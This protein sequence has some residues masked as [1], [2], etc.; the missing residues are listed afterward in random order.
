VWLDL[1]LFAVF[2]AFALLGAWRGALE[3]GLRLAAWVCGYAAAILAAALGGEALASALGTALW[4]GMPLA[5][6]LA[7]VATQALFAVAI[8][9]ARRRGAETE[10]GAGDRILG[11][12]FGATRGALLALLIGWLGLLGDA[13]R[14]EGMLTALPPLEGSV[15]AHWSGL[16]A[17]SGATAALG[18]DPGA[19]AVAA[20]AARP[21]ETLTSL[22]SVI[23]HPRVIALQRDGD[24]W[25]A[26]EA[27]DVE[28]ALSRPSA[29]ALTSDAALRRELAS[30]G[31]VERA[32]AEHPI[33]FERALGDALG[34]VSVRLAELRN[35]PEVRA[36]LEDP[37]VLGLVERGDALGLLAHPRFQSVIRRASAS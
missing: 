22:R 12:A 27:G 20:L 34:E 32:A 11:A 14:S 15:G 4:L 5:G 30:L 37:E 31:L 36:L 3:S 8:A 17:E 6:T 10:R 33:A 26:V 1:L 28:A 16:V 9:I 19:R 35:D 2:L 25:L 7:F 23:E 21:R 24:F 29:R 18:H 13:L